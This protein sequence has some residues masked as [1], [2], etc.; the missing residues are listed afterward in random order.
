MRLQPNIGSDRSWV[1][2]VAADYSENPPTSETLAIRFANAESK[3]FM[4]SSCILSPTPPADAQQFKDEFEKAQKHNAELTGTSAAEEPKA[5]APA[6]EDKK[7]EPAATEEPKEETKAEEKT[8][9]KAEEEK[10]D[11]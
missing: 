1:W 7:E 6:P 9:E 4:S 11:E 5:E 10:K 8:E 2:K 3:V